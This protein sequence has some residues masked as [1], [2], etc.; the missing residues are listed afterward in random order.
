M[1]KASPH[2][3]VW[4][5]PLLPVLLGLLLVVG[6][7]RPQQ[8]LRH[9]LF[10][11]YQRWRPRVYESVP[12]RIVDIDEASLAKL[13]QWPWSRRVLAELVDRLRAADVAALGFDVI[14]AEPDRLSPQAAA[15]LWQLRG[16]LRS[17]LAQLPDPDQL[18]AQSLAQ[19]P[20]V[21][22]LALQ[23][24]AGA[25]GPKPAQKA[26]WIRL[27]EAADGW[28]HG[29]GRAVTSL[30]R[31]EQAAQG[32]GVLTFVP[33]Q[34][35]VVR[36]VPLALRLGET[37]LPSLVSETLRVAQGQ[38]NIMLRS[39]GQ[40]SGLAE[41]RI[42]ALTMPTTPQGELWLHYSPNQPQRYVPAWQVLA[43]QVPPE[44]LQGHIALVGTS[45][46]GLMDMRFSPFGMVPGVET[47]AQALEQIL[48]GHYLTRPSWA[49]GLEAAL[50][51]VGG[52]GI[53]WLA[54]RLRALPAA[55]FGLLWLG[56]LFGGAWWAFAAQGL[57]LDAATPS[58]VALLSF[59]LCSLWHHLSSERQQ[60]W[61][62]NAFARYV[63]PNRVSHLL[64]NPEA[65]DL[66]GRRQ[67]CSFVFTD[68]AGF[69]RLM[70][71]IDPQTGVGLLNAYLDEMIAIAFRH[72]GTLDRIVGDAIAIMFSAPIPQPDHQQR[73]LSC[74]LEM[75]AFANRYTQ[76][77]QAQGLAFGHTR[78]GVHGGEVIVGN[79]GGST[80]F[81]YR[82]LGDAVNT[83]SRLESANKHLGTRLCVSGYIVAACPA[84]PVR[85]IGQLQVKG[86]SHA[87]S[88]FEPLLNDGLARTPLDLYAPAYQLL[89]SHSPDALA[90]FTAL[91]QTYPQDPLV[92]LHQR[93]LAQGETGELLVLREK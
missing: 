9:A 53:G 90:A 71:G 2:K 57:L 1:N 24:E 23:A 20:S 66:G 85:P 49:Q 8:V 73:A 34:D 38:Q 17:Q 54:L 11:Q 26:R 51:V 33:D 14:F 86:K 27:G 89:A 63:S 88:V 45:A 68:L 55:A 91:A 3:L 39:A 44:Q 62:M 28:L 81:D 6:E 10:D 31:L 35:G 25:A 50:V 5:L 56:A 32:N 59:L 52:L 48:S 83:T 40:E 29:F 92:T 19:T 58:V 87:L 64:E 78:I 65:M 67:E 36:H 7:S 13:G 12:V 79:L 47:H 93:R 43:G 21:V 74:A 30:P 41:V 84:Q 60:R 42:G 69:T 76:Q 77:L 46:Q 22:G 4:L 72:E 75:D 61:I 16:P 70:E 80:M 82:A 37:L 15:D 18:F